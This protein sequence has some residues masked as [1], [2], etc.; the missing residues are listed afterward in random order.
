MSYLTRQM[1]TLYTTYE[2][3]NCLPLP[4]PD[5]GPAI[6]LFGP[7]DSLNETLLTHFAPARLV[8]EMSRLGGPPYHLYIVQPSPG[9]FNGPV[10]TDNLTLAAAQASPFTWENPFP[11]PYIITPQRPVAQPMLLTRWKLLHTTPPAF[12]T[13]YSYKFNARYAGKGLDGQTS[14]QTCSASSFQSGEQLLVAFA[15]SEGSIGGPA[16]LSISGTSW[17]T[18]PY[19]SSVGPLR[20]ETFLHQSTPEVPLQGAGGQASLSLKG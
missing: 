1:R 5:Q 11:K 10:F 2:S 13:S 16:S 9:R 4:G 3:P 6:M 15:L 12:S 19:S 14:V 7:A 8:S 18:T 17:S 20:L